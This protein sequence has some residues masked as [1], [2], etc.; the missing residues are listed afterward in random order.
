MR[1]SHLCASVQH[2]FSC[3]AGITPF[4]TTNGGYIFNL[5]RFLLECFTDRSTSQTR[6][7]EPQSY[8]QQ[9]ARTMNGSMTQSLLQLQYMQMH[10]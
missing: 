5:S 7:Q 2:S 4:Y 3:E 1:L 10:V 6:M 9:T 8:V